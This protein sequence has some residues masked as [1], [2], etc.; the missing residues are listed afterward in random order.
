MQTLINKMATRT[1]I[2]FL[3]ILIFC[4][5]ALADTQMP[6]AE[7]PGIDPAANRAAFLDFVQGSL[8]SGFMDEWR[9]Q[10]PMQSMEDVGEYLSIFNL[11][12]YAYQDGTGFNLNTDEAK[13]LA[14]FR[15]KA[16]VVQAEAFPK[17]R[18]A[19]GPILRKQIA[20]LEISAVTSGQGFKTVRFSG[21]PFSVAD[22]ID[23]FHAEVKVVLFQLRFEKAEYKADRNAPTLKTLPVSSLN[24][25]ALV[26]WEDN[27]QY[28]EVK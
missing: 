2:C 24:D 1:V 20:Q 5:G 19:F 10:R 27:L 18:D 6:A 3:M 15:Q 22:N 28:E 9:G 8:E 25:K 13:L 12:A 21:R 7:Q 16:E 11:W 14:A 4:G 26:I 23:D 17:L